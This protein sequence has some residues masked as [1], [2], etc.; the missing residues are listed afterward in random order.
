[1]TLNFCINLSTML[2]IGVK[3][4]ILFTARSHGCR[5]C[6]D[7]RTEY[8]ATEPPAIVAFNLLIG[9]SYRRRHFHKGKEPPFIR[10][11]KMQPETEL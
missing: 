7:Y 4:I 1:M 10:S 5:F 11:K 9:N 2:V 3:I 8:P 6:T